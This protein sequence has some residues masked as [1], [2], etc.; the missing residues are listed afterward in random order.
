M[1]NPNFLG[2]GKLDH[3]GVAVDD[4]ESALKTYTEQWGYALTHREVI[5]DAGLELIFLEAEDMCVELVRSLRDDSPVAKFLETRGP[6]VHH[7][8]VRVEDID[9]A[10]AELSARGVRLLD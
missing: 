3:V 1:E 2:I 6:G 10:L 7:V 5:E 9:K 4:V 8:A